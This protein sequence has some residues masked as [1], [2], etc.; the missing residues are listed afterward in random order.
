MIHPGINA[1]P[2]KKPF[3]D[4]HLTFS[5]GGLLTADCLDVHAEPSRGLF[6]SLSLLDMASATGW[7]K[8]D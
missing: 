4:S 1:V 5:T 3:L 7:L 8:D 6:Q 2:L